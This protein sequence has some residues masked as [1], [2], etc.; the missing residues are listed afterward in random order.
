MGVQNISAKDIYAL[1]FPLPP[2]NEQYRIVA[3]IEELISKFDK[4]IES[5]KAA[6]QKLDVFGQAVLKN[7]FEGKLTAS[8][9]EVNKDK[10]ETPEQLLARIKQQREEHYEQQLEEWKAAV[11]EWEKEGKSGKKPNKP[12]KVNDLPTLTEVELHGFTEATG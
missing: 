1:P 4:G 7:A 11:K 10:L 3:K 9:R 8:W 2:F 6:R 5:L 12:K